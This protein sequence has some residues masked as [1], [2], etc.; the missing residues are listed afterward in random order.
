MFTAVSKPN[1]KS[2][3]PRS[4]SIVLGTPTTL[5]PSACSRVAAP[6]VSS[7]PIAIR[8]STPRPARLSLIRSTPERSPPSSA[9]GLVRDVPRIVPPRGR[10]PRTAW[11]SRGTVSPSS[12]PRQPS[13]KPTN[14]YPYSATPLRTTARMTALRPGQSPPPV[15]TPTLMGATIARAGL[16]GPGLRTWFPAAFP[17]A[18]PAARARCPAAGCSPPGAGHPRPVSPWPAGRTCPRIPGRRA[19]RSPASPRR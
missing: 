16:A 17:R 3:A 10:I 12:G 9:K 14:S 2:V 5:T 11:T 6:S 1:V 4:L 15:R 18:C 13:R 8:A 7:P 19:L